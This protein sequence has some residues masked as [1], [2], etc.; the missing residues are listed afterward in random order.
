MPKKIIAASA[1]TTTGTNFL[2]HPALV[3]GLSLTAGV[4]FW[5]DGVV[6]SEDGVA[7]SEDGTLLSGLA[8]VPWLFDPD[9]TAAAAGFVSDMFFTCPLPELFQT[10]P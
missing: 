5:E 9:S 2:R 4:V 3:N 1:S 10:L 6:F 7:F 8:V